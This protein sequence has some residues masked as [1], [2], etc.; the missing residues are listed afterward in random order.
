[1]GRPEGSGC[2]CFPNALLT[3]CIGTL[4]CG[5]RFVVVDSEAGMEHIARGTVRSPDILLITSDPGARGMRT[6]GRIRD[7]AESLG[8]SRDRIY[9]VVNR[10][11]DDAVASSNIPLIARIPED[12]GVGDADLAGTPIVGIP[13]ASPARAAVRALAG[14]LVGECA[15]R[16]G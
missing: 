2:Y 6:A 16:R 10:D 3:E 11:R 13:A 15:Q 8:L 9:L 5:Y 4:E 14:W 1:M 12:P 7:L